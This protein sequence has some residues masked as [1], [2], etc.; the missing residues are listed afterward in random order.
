[1]MENAK[2]SVIMPVYGVEAYVGKANREHTE[3]DL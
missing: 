1:M 2:I 3:T